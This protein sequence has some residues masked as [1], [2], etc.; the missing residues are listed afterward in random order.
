MTGPTVPLGGTEIRKCQD[1]N[2]ANGFKVSSQFRTAADQ[3]G[4]DLTTKLGKINYLNDLMCP[5]SL[6]AR[7][8]KCGSREDPANYDP[9]MLDYCSAQLQE[10]SY[11]D[12]VITDDANQDEIIITS[13]VQATYEYRTEKTTVAREGSAADLGDQ[14]IND[15]EYCDTIT[16]GGYCGDKSDGCSKI[17][18][19]TDVDVLP[20][21]NPNLLK[22]IKDPITGIITWTIAPI[23]V[24]NGNAIGVECAGDRI[25]A[26]SNADSAVAWN[27]HDG[28]QNEWNIVIL[29]NAPSTNHNALF[30]RTS[31]EVWIG[32]V[33]GYIY[34][35]IDGGQTFNAAHEATWT[36]Q[37][38]NAIYA[39]DKD[40]VYAA[41][42][43]GVILKS[44]DGGQT[45]EDVTEV[46]TTGN[47]NLNVVIVPP[48]RPKE[49]LVGN[50]KIYR[51]KNE[52]VTLAAISFDGDGVGTVDDL[53]FCGPCA[54]DVMWI[55]HNDA[56]PRARILRDLSG[57]A[58]GADVEVVMDW[59]KVIP[60]GIELNALA[61]CGVNTAI[62][63][64]GNYNGYPVVVK[65]S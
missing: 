41:G 1:P 46:A 48:E 7:Y 16:C 4:F 34:K 3:I 32:C 10:Y 23:L 37:T 64:G 65:I 19:V 5:F 17:Y 55:L 51:S 52:G 2:K 11:E 18:A 59:F 62:A 61:C 24:F 29:A 54:G 13:P 12:L 47:G 42:N 35:S 50:N 26:S 45:W 56:G 43:A 44:R 33:N 31:R 38:I 15:I 49:V 58:G 22:G 39:Y 60:T 25:F 40:L 21:G 20:Y 63:P 28:D 57:G 14:P 27:S 36:T 53:A 30:A 9:L 6:R 8:A